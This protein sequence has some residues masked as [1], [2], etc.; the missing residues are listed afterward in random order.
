M[1][2]PYCF[3][4][5]V[6]GPIIEPGYVCP[7][8]HRAEWH[9]HVLGCKWWIG[10]RD[11][12]SQ[13]YKPYVQAGYQILTWPLSKLREIPQIEALEIL[14]AR[15]AHEN[16]WRPTVTPVP[17]E[18]FFM[19]GKRPVREEDLYEPTLLMRIR[20]PIAMRAYPGQF[21]VYERADEFQRRVL[22]WAPEPEWKP[23]P[24]G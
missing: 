16:P 1:T 24:T 23:D 21:L 17:A 6:P 19:A 22:E 10:P 14:D 13:A 8:C 12:K 4:D 9:Q 11:P 2:C 18:P 5:T 7:G 15:T 20:H 3:P